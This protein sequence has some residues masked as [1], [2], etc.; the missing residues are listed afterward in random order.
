[1]SEITNYRDLLC[2]QTSMDLVLLVYEIT[3]KYPRDERY[4][5]TSHTRK[6]AVAV[7]SKP[8]PNSRLPNPDLPTPDCRLPNPE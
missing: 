2:R 6:S 5:L 7:P 3:S 8:I 1:M 4:G